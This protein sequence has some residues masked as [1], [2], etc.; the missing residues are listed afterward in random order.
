MP[1]LR[2]QLLGRFCASYGCREIHN[3][4]ASKVQELLCY[5]A[6]YR[7]PHA[8]ETLATL[9][10]GDSSASQA[11]KNLRQTLWQLQ[12]ALDANLGPFKQRVVRVEA[13]W[14]QLNPALALR[15]DVAEFEQA[16]T[17]DNDMPRGEL[18]PTMAQN[19]Q[20][21]IQLYQAD[22][23]EG[24]YQDW[25]LFERE[26]LQSIYLATLDRLIRYCEA[27]GDYRHGLAYAT[28]VLRYDPARERT[29]RQLMRLYHIAGDRTAAL[30]QYQRCVS[31]LK[32]ELDVPPSTRTVKLRE[33]IDAEELEPSNSFPPGSENN[34]NLLPD[35][36]RHLKQ[37]RTTLSDMQKQVQQDIRKVELALIDR[38]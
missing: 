33:K 8:R 32:A 31:A 12:A 21:A 37:V 17:S 2:L 35:V 14:V 4:E 22:L 34:S 3:F 7:K 9:F 28:E 1:V 27:T 25:C 19:L 29:H 10:W 18:D 26:R 30:R 20:K 15:L 11:K 13:D 38:R 24:C 36:L 6:L 16:C 23:L 5:L